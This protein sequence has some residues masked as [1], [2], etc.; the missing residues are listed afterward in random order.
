MDDGRS[1]RIC[2]GQ[3]SSMIFQRLGSLATQDSFRWKCLVFVVRNLR[4]VCKCSSFD[5]RWV[6][7]C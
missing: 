5:S 6:L 1:E 3:N 7:F 2:F 4:A